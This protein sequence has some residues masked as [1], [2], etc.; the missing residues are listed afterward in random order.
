LLLAWSPRTRFSVFSRSCFVKFH[1]PIDNG[2]AID[3]II[4][5]CKVNA[6]T[7]NKKVLFDR[8]DRE[9]IKTLSVDCGGK[10]C[11]APSADLNCFS[12]Q[13][14][15]LAIPQSLLLGCPLM[16]ESA[17]RRVKFAVMRASHSLLEVYVIIPE[18]LLGLLNGL[19]FGYANVCKHSLF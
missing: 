15:G 16:T 13:E 7:K 11:F 10:E 6:T 8:H 2:Q 19:R 14:L 12:C 17:H 9:R 5:W 3:L 18:R 4:A 1:D